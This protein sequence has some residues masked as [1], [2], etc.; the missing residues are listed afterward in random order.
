MRICDPRRLVYDLDESMPMN[1]SVT[2]SE[3]LSGALPKSTSVM[4]VGKVNLSIS[5][6]VNVM[7]G[8]QE[9]VLYRGAHAA[10]RMAAVN[11]M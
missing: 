3:V 7:G 9:C 8:V 10:A 5:E 1:S 2:L 6:R 4:E 11:N